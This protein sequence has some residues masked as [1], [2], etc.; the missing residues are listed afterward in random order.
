MFAVCLSS[1]LPGQAYSN[2]CTLWPGQCGLRNRQTSK[3]YWPGAIGR[4]QA[5]SELASSVEQQP[6]RSEIVAVLRFGLPLQVYANFSVCRL[7]SILYAAVGFVPGQTSQS[8][9]SVSFVSLGRAG[10]VLS[11]AL[12]WFQFQQSTTTVFNGSKRQYRTF[13]V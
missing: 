6:A 9:A 12:G 8:I 10:W 4:T 11:A 7:N 5:C 2:S 13:Q 1:I 3:A